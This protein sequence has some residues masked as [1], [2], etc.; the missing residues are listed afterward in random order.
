MPCSVFIQAIS[1]QIFFSLLIGKRKRLNDTWISWKIWIPPQLWRGN[2]FFSCPYLSICSAE[3]LAFRGVLCREQ[4][5]LF[6][7]RYFQIL[8]S[9]FHTISLSNHD[10][11]HSCSTNS[12]G[13][14][15]LELHHYIGS[16]MKTVIQQRQCNWH[17]LVCV[18]IWWIQYTSWGWITVIQI[19][20]E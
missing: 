11:A 17:L 3:A 13:S 9:I 12:R 16:E 19:L 15:W 7:E 4:G 2:S 8:S 1:G 6:S 14:A 20:W 10:T 18:S 5:E